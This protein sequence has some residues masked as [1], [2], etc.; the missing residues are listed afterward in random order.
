MST[1]QLIPIYDI[2]DQAELHK[3][4]NFGFDFVT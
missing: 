2:T 4:Q 1:A 3:E